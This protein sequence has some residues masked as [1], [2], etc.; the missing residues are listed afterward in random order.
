MDHIGSNLCYL[1]FTVGH[2][3]KQHDLPWNSAINTKWNAGRK[4]W[5]S[6]ISMFRKP[7]V[8][9]VYDLAE[10]M[11]VNMM[12]WPMMTD[13]YRV[14]NIAE[15]ASGV[16]KRW[17]DRSDPRTAPL[18]PRQ[19][20]W[21]EVPP[22]GSWRHHCAKKLREGLHPSVSSAAPPTAFNFFPGK[23]ALLPASA[24]ATSQSQSATP[25]VF[26]EGGVESSAPKRRKK[27]ALR[28]LASRSDT[29]SGESGD[30]SAS[31]SGSGA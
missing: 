12:G 3:A 7:E 24:S 31:D 5:R 29:T 17:I 20:Q 30:S 10:A 11:S 27:R 28:S 25:F 2:S 15:V 14:I 22:T 8:K 1:D 13:R 19:Y 26:T 16:K 18:R 6:T 23:P 9:N 4:G 21:A